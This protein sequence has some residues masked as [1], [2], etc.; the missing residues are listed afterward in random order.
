ME[1]EFDDQ[2]ECYYENSESNFSSKLNEFIF[3]LQNIVIEDDFL[4]LRNDFF[5]KYYSKFDNFQEENKHE[6]YKIFELY[7]SIIE[8]YLTKVSKSYDNFRSCKTE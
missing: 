2:E 7:V 1:Q 6:Y 5:K 8:G 3:N 4:E